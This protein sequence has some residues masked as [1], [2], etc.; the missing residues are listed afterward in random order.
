MPGRFSKTAFPSLC[1]RPRIWNVPV[2]TRLW[3]IARTVWRYSHRTLI[4]LLTTSPVTSCREVRYIWCVFFALMRKPARSIILCRA[5]PGN[6]KW[7][8]ESSVPSGTAM[9][10]GNSFLLVENVRSSAYREY[11]HPV[12][13]ASFTSRISS[14]CATRLEMTG[15]QGLPCGS[16]LS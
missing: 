8:A 7:D 2:L 13:D 14:K 5:L 6:H 4:F 9:S 11:V 12:S 3:T 16:E 1:V 10:A 15:E